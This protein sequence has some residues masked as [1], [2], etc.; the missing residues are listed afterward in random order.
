MIYLQHNSLIEDLPICVI[1]KGMGIETDQE[2][3]QMV[4]MENLELFS[5]SIEQARS[6]GVM[7]QYQALE[8]IGKHVRPSKLNL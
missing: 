3:I 5:L 7:T 2:A 1:L 6:L 8:Y 4:G